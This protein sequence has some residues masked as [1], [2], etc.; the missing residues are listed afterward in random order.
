MHAYIAYLRVSTDRQGKSGLGLEA[1]QAAIAAFTCGD[2][3]I[4][5][6]FVEV[7]SGRIS[8]RPQ[9]AAALER[10]RQCG[11]TLLIA[12]L[13]RLARDVA[14]ISGLMKSDVRFRATDL[15]TDD[16]FRIH[17]E[18][19]IAEDESRRIS[20]RTKAALAAA[21]A[22]GVRLG[23]FRG[24]S[25]SEEDRASSAAV[26]AAVARQRA[27]SLRPILDELRATGATSL[28]ALAQGLNSRSVPAPRGGQWNPVQVLR[29]I[30]AGP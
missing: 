8:A 3:K 26:R 20:A 13:D 25:P 2:D 17:L 11:A 10:C 4:L 28:R 7:E 15:A 5:E 30:R 24:R 27:N 14:F 22:R 29:V 18:A 9:L 21:K 1:Q 23:G 12:K 6:T 16:P 19:A